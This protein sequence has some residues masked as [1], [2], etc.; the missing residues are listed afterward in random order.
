MISEND[1]EHGIIEPDS[2]FGKELGFTSEMFDGWLWKSGKFIY[3]SF[4]IS[5]DEGKGN[6]RKLF[7]TILS[8]GYGV[9]VP[10]P[11]AKMRSICD[12]MGFK[13]AYEPFSEDNPEIIEVLV[14]EK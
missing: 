12:K 14:K 11:F 10:T 5:K 1:D 3:V 9:K 13:S 6:L 8:K 2:K 7:E 4:I